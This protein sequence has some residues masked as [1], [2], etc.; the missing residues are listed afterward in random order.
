MAGKTVKCA[1]CG[2]AFRIPA[3]DAAATQQGP[4]AKRDRPVARRLTAAA[5]GSDPA[6]PAPEAALDELLGGAASEAQGPAAAWQSPVPAR[7][8]AAPPPLPATGGAKK[9]KSFDRAYF[10]IAVV[11]IFAGLMTVCFAILSVNLKWLDDKTTA[12]AWAIAGTCIAGVGLPI[13]LYAVRHNLLVGVPSVLGVAAI[14]AAVWV[15]QPFTKSD[16]GPVKRH[17]VRPPS[18]DAPAP[19]SVPKAPPPD[20]GPAPPTDADK[21][22]DK[23]AD[24]AIARFAELNELLASARDAASSAAAIAKVP[25]LLRRVEELNNE[26]RILQSQGAR[27]SPQKQQQLDASTKAMET[28]QLDRLL[29]QA[30][31]Y[32]D[33]MDE[34]T[35]EVSPGGPPK[36]KP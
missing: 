6:P 29:Q 2:E 20:P 1:K 4:P 32:L 11:V 3:A 9:P 10:N 31:Q 30:P 22:L 33:L 5:S 18:L 34:L 23:L 13:V 8:P 7:R 36:K 28:Q 14:L 12:M 19:P 21:R 24:E 15:Y 16:E 26:R 17:G 25:A 27:L 35:R